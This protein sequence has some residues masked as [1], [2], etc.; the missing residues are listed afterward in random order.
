MVILQDR[1]SSIKKGVAE[2]IVR[3]DLRVV[4]QNGIQCASPSVLT[5]RETSG[6]PVRLREDERRIVVTRTTLE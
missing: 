1:I 4:S 2:V 6:V 3:G 5:T